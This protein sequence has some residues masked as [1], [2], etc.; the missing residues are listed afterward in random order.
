MGN[1]V[2][3][4]VKDKKYEVQQEYRFVVSV[5]FHS[6]SEKAIYLKVSEDLRRFMAPLSFW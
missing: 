4:Y 5:K 1:R 6:P 2:A 3:L